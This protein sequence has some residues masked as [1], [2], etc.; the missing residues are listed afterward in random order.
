MRV[1]G[2]DIYKSIDG[3]NSFEQETSWKY[4]NTLG[5]PYVH[6]DIEVLQYIDGIIYVGCDG[7]IIKSTDGGTS[8]TDLSTGLG[9]QQFYRIACSASNKNVVAGGAQDN[10]SVIKS[11]PSHQWMQYFGADGTDCIIDPYNENI[12][13]GSSQLGYIVK[14]TDG[15]ATLTSSFTKPPEDGQGNWV[16]PITMDPNNNNRIYAGYYNLYRH[17]NAG[18]S[19]DWVNTSSNINFD[20][21]LYSIETCPSNSD[22]IYVS[23]ETSMYKSTNITDASPTWTQFSLISGL[24][25][26]IDIAVD[27]YNENR[28]AYSTSWGEVVLSNN[29]GLNWSIITDDLPVLGF[30][31]VKS[32]VFDRSPDQ[33]IYIA[34]DGIIFYKS[35]SVTDWTIFSDTLP[36]VDLRELELYYDKEVQE[37]SRIRVA[38][39]GRGLW[40]SPLYDDRVFEGSVL[41][42]TNSTLKSE[43]N[44][45]YLFPNP[46]STTLHIQLPTDGEKTVISIANLL[47]Q[48]LSTNTFDT[49]N[50]LNLL[51]VNIKEL[52]DG[53]YPVT[54]LRGATKLVKKIVIE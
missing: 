14:T 6:I 10:G 21:L 16:T 32:I 15:G 23:T 34:I 44:K 13:Y 53:T 2:R 29:G 37:D 22:V 7:G 5:L 54:I 49:H 41:S 27:P 30:K 38:T 48:V 28:V 33:G 46:V 31:A 4:N 19:G 25:T 45:I 52:P 35:N 36:N 50:G 40:E 18:I 20:K 26:I 39:Y 42:T 24:G 8:Y 12:I 9:I 43:L 11:N 3:G 1:G 47:G 51:K 17:D